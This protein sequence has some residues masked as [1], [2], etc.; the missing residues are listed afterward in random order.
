[1]RWE[2]G[3]QTYI[4]GVLNCTPDSFSDGGQHSGVDA[5]VQA[6]ERMWKAGAHI[7]DIGGA[8][9][10]PDAKPVDVA[11]ELSRVLPVVKT[12]KERHPEILISLDTF[13]SEVARQ[14]VAAGAV[15]INDVS[16]GLYDPKMLPTVAE[17]GV[18]LSLMHLRGTPQTMQNTGNL[19][20]PQGVVNGVQFELHARVSAALQAGIP[21]WNLIIDPGIG[22]AKNLEQ[23]LALLR[24]SETLAVFDPYYTRARLPLLL[25]PSRKS[26]L[27]T[28][29][30]RKDGQGKH[31]QSDAN[32]RVHATVAAATAAVGYGADVVRVHDVD[33]VA[34]AVR[35]ADA[36]YR[37]G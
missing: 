25:G 11:T 16:A 9:T 3:S 18:P 19:D 2:W 15:L 7:I 35:I 33:E 20:Y 23:N 14:G 12:L 4:M 37:T 21:L 24:D 26:F 29:L 17:L 34:Q 32:H 36:I 10:R 31:F 27:G 6:A 22:F 8:S 28:L 30:A 1:M 13:H 5:A